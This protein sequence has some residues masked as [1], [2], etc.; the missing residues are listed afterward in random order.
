L[1]ENFIDSNTCHMLWHKTLPLVGADV[2]IIAITTS[3]VA[4]NGDLKMQLIDHPPRII[5]DGRLNPTADAWHVLL[6]PDQQDLEYL[7]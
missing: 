3:Q 5:S 6:L 1:S 7:V 4:I 2:R